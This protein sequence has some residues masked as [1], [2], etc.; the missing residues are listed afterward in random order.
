MTLVIFLFDIAICIF[1]DSNSF[2][3]DLMMLILRQKTGKKTVTVSE[4]CGTVSNLHIHSV[5]MVLMIIFHQGTIYHNT[6][7]KYVSYLALKGVGF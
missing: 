6:H 7:T 5:K 4:G 2:L 3:K 1:D